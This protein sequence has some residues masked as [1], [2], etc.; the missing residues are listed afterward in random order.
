M[1]PAIRHEYKLNKIKS[2]LKLYQISDQT[3]EAVRESEEHAMASGHHSLVRK[4]V[5]ELNIT[6]QLDILNHVCLTTE[7]NVV[8]G[9]RAGDL[10]TQKC[11]ESYSVSYGKMRG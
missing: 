3:V 10:L 2:L 4:N 9:A 8:T 11:K 6:F 1:R 7:G 5:E